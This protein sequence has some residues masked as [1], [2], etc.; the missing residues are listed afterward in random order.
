MEHKYRNFWLNNSCN[1]TMVLLYCYTAFDKR[2]LYAQYIIFIEQ[3]VT[4]SGALVEDSVRSLL[5]LSFYLTGQTPTT[6]C[7]VFL[8][9]NP[10]LRHGVD[11]WSSDEQVFFCKPHTNKVCKLPIECH[12]FLGRA[13]FCIRNYFIAFIH[14][15]VMIC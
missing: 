14:I 9:S 5:Y 7:P 8:L 3:K 2:I 4:R 11:K 6:A 10:L 12:I 15:F 1:Q 13:I